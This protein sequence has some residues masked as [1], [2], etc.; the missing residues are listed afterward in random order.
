MPEITNTSTSTEATA[1]TSE[2]TRIYEFCMLLAYPLSQKEE[3]DLMKE[4]EKLFEE[5]GGKQVAKDF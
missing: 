5:A 3:S 2:N 1:D 4:I